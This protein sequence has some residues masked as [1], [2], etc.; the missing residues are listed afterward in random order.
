M[1]LYHWVDVDTQVYVDGKSLRRNR[2]FRMFCFYAAYRSKWERVQMTR[3]KCQGDDF[4]YVKR[5]E[6]VA[7][8]LTPKKLYK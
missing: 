1:P 7:L 4:K 3:F 8:V 5:V 6:Y 2:H